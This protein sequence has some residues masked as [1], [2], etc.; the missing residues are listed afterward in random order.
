MA[1][2]AVVAG[3]CLLLSSLAAADAVDAVDPRSRL[4]ALFAPGLRLE[5]DYAE[6]GQSGDDVFSLSV[7]LAAVWSVISSPGD[8]LVLL[9]EIEAMDFV[10]SVETGTGEAPAVNP[11][12]IDARSL[13]RTGKLKAS[14]TRG[15]ASLGTD[16]RSLVALG[17]LGFDADPKILAARHRHIRD[18][19]RHI[20][21]RAIFET[22]A[23]VF[24]PLG[25][26]TIEQRSDARA[27]GLK[28]VIRHAA[29][30]KGGAEPAAFEVTLA[31]P[32]VWKV[33]GLSYAPGK[34]V[35][36][37]SARPRPLPDPRARLIWGG[38]GQRE[39]DWEASLRAKGAHG[40][41]ESI[42]IALRVRELPQGGVRIAQEK[43]LDAPRLAQGQVFLLTVSRRLQASHESA[44]KA[45]GVQ[46][47]LTG[48]IAAA[49]VAEGAAPRLSAVF[50]DGRFRE[51][52][53]PAAPAAKLFS[54]W[55]AVEGFDLAGVELE[56]SP[57][58]AAGLG[59]AIAEGPLRRRLEPVLDDALQGAFTQ[60]PRAPRPSS[61]TVPAA[62]GKSRAELSMEVEATNPFREVDLTVEGRSV[63]ER[64][65]L[66]NRAWSGAVTAARRGEDAATCC[67]TVVVDPIAVLQP[68]CELNVEDRLRT[69]PGVKT[70]A[71][72]R[73]VE[74]R[75][76]V[77]CRQI[78]GPR[79]GAP[80]PPNAHKVEP[81]PSIE[82]LAPPDLKPW[83]SSAERKGLE[84]FLRGLPDGRE[85]V[86]AA[87]QR[88][89]EMDGSREGSR[90]GAIW[91]SE[92]TSALSGRVG[93][94]ARD[95]LAGQLAPSSPFPVRVLALRLIASAAPPMSAEDKVAALAPWLGDPDLAF[96]R[97]AGR[98]LSTLRIPESVEA[99][100]EA[101]QA[102]ER[103]PDE[104]VEQ[105]ELRLSLAADLYR[106]LGE[107]VRTPSAGSIAA[108][109][110]RLEKKVPD[111]PL[112]PSSSA[113]ATI[114]EAYRAF[115]DVRF[116]PVAF[117]L[118]ASSSMNDLV[119]A[120]GIPLPPDPGGKAIPVKISKLEWVEREMNAVLTDL[121]PGTRVHIVGFNKDAMCFRDA[122]ASLTAAVLAEARRFVGSLRSSRGTHLHAGL[123]KAFRGG[124][125]GS[126]CL[127]TD[128][129]PTVGPGPHEIERAVFHW[130][131]LGGA[132]IVV[133]SFAGDV[134]KP[135]N[136]CSRLARQ[137]FGWVRVLD[138]K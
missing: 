54:G 104:T 93:K 102:H 110:T 80:V 86:T 39:I 66:L 121:E 109:W 43:R 14:V 16:V 92:L 1:R 26:E 107:G 50:V 68:R 12:P 8:S 137:H 76:S 24:Q 70:K 123:E 21:E 114:V 34:A 61:V 71:E 32:I 28:R 135:E 10:V 29:Q 30:G 84:E 2:F 41:E 57:S 124:V 18:L 51:L 38:R 113:H 88:Y 22:F 77:G 3:S 125:A 90:I 94:D 122:P 87:L 45:A 44:G 36:V 105:K 101:L 134:V 75:S 13:A 99:L 82:P 42:E 73:A 72:Q 49:V 7:H 23:D 132:R 89:A 58:G 108:I 27:K 97:F 96:A 11:R 17:E 9:A 95:A 52:G 35:F 79:V 74:L 133:A 19:Q 47:S 106:L 37:S 4:D 118:D 63:K 103:A 130:N 48:R 62:D 126:I 120:V 56:L 53:G 119:S 33:G 40:E 55:D 116:P 85:G 31:P 127:F 100:L 111:D 5:T 78:L 91:H 136:L 69:A 131:Y 64:S 129:A 138:R 81:G 46:Q 20:L 59:V 117:V 60:P 25:A 112:S 128:G 15:G 6:R 83:L 115:G 67:Y 98:F 65:F